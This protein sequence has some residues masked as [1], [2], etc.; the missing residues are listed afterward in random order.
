MHVTIIFKMS[1]DNQFQELIT[2]RRRLKLGKLIIMLCYY[3]IIV[4]ILYYYI[5]F[6]LLIYLVIQCQMAF[7]I[8]LRIL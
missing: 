1:V 7:F 6:I 2:M 8:M 4:T 3:Y 5:Y